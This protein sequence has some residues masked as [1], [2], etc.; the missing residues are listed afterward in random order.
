MTGVQ[1]CALPIC[2]PFSKIEVNVNYICVFSSKYYSYVNLKSLLK[3][4][5]T[6]KLI[7]YKRVSVFI[8]YLDNIT[9]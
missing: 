6:D 4:R 2:L 7:L 8:R 1:T 3:G 5:H 9:K